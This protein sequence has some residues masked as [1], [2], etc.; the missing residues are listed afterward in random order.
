MCEDFCGNS[1]GCAQS[2]FC[3]RQSAL[4]E[5]LE[6]APSHFTQSYILPQRMN[7]MRKRHSKHQTYVRS[8]N[9]KLDNNVDFLTHDVVECSARKSTI[10]P[11]I[12]MSNSI[13]TCL[14]DDSLPGLAVKRV[15]SPQSSGSPNLSDNCLTSKMKVDTLELRR[16]QKK[17]DSIKEKSNILLDRFGPNIL[18]QFKE[19]FVRDTDGALQTA[20]PIVYRSSSTACVSPV[21]KTAPCA[22]PSSDEKPLQRTQFLTNSIDLSN[23]NYNKFVSENSLIHNGSFTSEEYLSEAVKKNNLSNLIASSQVNLCNIN[24]NINSYRMRSKS[25][26]T[27]ELLGGL[28]FCK[29]EQV[30]D[31]THTNLGDKIAL[32]VQLKRNY[33]ESKTSCGT[34]SN[35]SSDVGETSSPGSSNGS[36]ISINSPHAAA[37]NTNN[38][39]LVTEANFDNSQNS[40]GKRMKGGKKKFKGS[41]KLSKSLHSLFPRACSGSMTLHHED[42]TE[43]MR[44]DSLYQPIDESLLQFQNIDKQTIYLSQLNSQLTNNNN[45]NTHITESMHVTKSYTKNKSAKCLISNNLLLPDCP[46]NSSRAKTPHL[47]K[48][49]F[50]AITRGKSKSLKSLSKS[51]FFSCVATKDLWYNKLAQVVAEEKESTP[52]NTNIQVSYYDTVSGAD[53][54]SILYT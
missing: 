3:G 51:N 47:N 1:V 30:Y 54:V 8:K 11:H 13:S 40:A 42:S 50:S 9:T 35:S 2:L 25:L 34:H 19:S 7:A 24:S 33:F 48:G 15:L 6:S 53:I 27:K 43:T 46:S 12:V 45:N 39:N 18:Y 52:P 41:K 31:A 49:R 22:S 44:P 21:R 4:N 37:N 32:A 20:Q 28:S 29:Q 38:A 26:S 14:L 23:A 10:S 5:T 16:N 36:S 17:K